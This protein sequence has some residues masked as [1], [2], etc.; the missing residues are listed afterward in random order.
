MIAQSFGQLKDL[1]SSHQIDS[2]M[3]KADGFTDAN[4]RKRVAIKDQKTPSEVKN[5]NSG[6]LMIE[7]R[8]K[9]PQAATSCQQM[10]K[11]KAKQIL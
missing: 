1:K 6:Y 2:L 10:M 5:L 4:I 11:S 8:R 7:Q 9:E 3:N